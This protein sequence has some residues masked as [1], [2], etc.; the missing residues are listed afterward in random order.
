M[1][2]RIRGFAY[3]AL[4]AA[5]IAV[6]SFT[7]A[8]QQVP[9]LPQPPAN[10]QLFLQVHAKGDQV[11]ICK[12]D[13]T[14]F[15]WAL[16]APDAQLFDKDGKSFG[17]HFAG[18]SW[19]ANDGS[20]VTGKA[21]ANSPSP[22]D[23]SIPWLLV[24]IVS[25]DGSGVL[26]RATSIQ[27]VNTQGGKAPASGC[28]ASHIGQEVR[29]P[30]SADYRFYAPQEPSPTVASVLDR[31]ISAIEK[32]V[33][34]AAEAMPEDKFN[35]TPES[36]NI[37][38]DDYKGVRTFAVQVKHVAA[39]N[40]FIWSPLTGDKVPENIKDG[41]GPAD[42]KSKADILKFLKDSFALGHKAAATLTAENMLQNPGNSKSTRLRLA[43]FGVAHAY[44][45]YGQMVEY[46]RMN[47]IVPPASRAKSE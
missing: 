41:N 14:Q 18:P 42:L 4:F 13:A 20:R 47:G 8:A 11:Y 21:V 34:D 36:L 16:K 32:Q 43:T 44:D 35:F 33:V 30:Y 15:A 29:V 46:L 12:C 7:V 38:G 5:T 37:P 45:H 22:D 10:E 27:R 17:K 2:N 1:Y 28:D 24:T 3:A 39:S 26:S 40:Y 19:E 31:E 25:H 6:V 23:K 9:Q